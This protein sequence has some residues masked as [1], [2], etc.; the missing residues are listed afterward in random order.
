MSLYWG[1]SE[2]KNEKRYPSVKERALVGHV[3]KL[4]CPHTE[5]IKSV[6]MMKDN[7]DRGSVQAIEEKRSKYRE[8]ER[9]PPQAVFAHLI[10]LHPASL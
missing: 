4:M 1:E 5:K 10:H 9:K 7:R 8:K 3:I 2:K 6:T